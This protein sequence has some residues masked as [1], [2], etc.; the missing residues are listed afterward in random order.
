MPA[1][2]PINTSRIS[3]Y[4]SQEEPSVID[5]L[6]ISTPI[7]FTTLLDHSDP[8]KSSPLMINLMDMDFT[9][10]NLRDITTGTAVVPLEKAGKSLSLSSRSE[11]SAS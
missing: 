7:L 8:L 11:I 9:C 4:P 6:S 2:N 3:Q 1:I 10:S 5:F